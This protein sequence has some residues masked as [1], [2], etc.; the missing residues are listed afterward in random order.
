MGSPCTL[1]HH[2]ESL[3]GH[4]QQKALESAS[5]PQA[6]SLVQHICCL[7]T[8]STNPGP[9]LKSPQWYPSVNPVYHGRGR[10]EANLLPGCDS[11]EIGEKAKH[12]GTPKGNTQRSVPP[13]PLT[14]PPPLLLTT[15]PQD[16]LWSG[17]EPQTMSPQCVWTETEVGRTGEPGPD[18][19]N[20][21]LPKGSH[22]A[23]SKK[24]GIKRKWR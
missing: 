1:S 13:L 23:C 6:K 24:E 15:P 12:H 5:P 11:G 14:T 3:H 4:F 10:W 18:L 7:A 16:P 20:K 17:Q 21:R 22:S 8:P 2:S 9:L 19:P